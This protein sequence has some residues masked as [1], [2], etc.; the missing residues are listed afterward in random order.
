MLK[1]TIEEQSERVSKRVEW[2]ES[3]YKKWEERFEIPF[4]Q[5]FNIKAL[6]GLRHQFTATQDDHVKTK[7]DLLWSMQKIESHLNLK[8]K[9]KNKYIETVEKRIER[10]QTSLNSIEDSIKVAN[11]NG[12]ATDDLKLAK[13]IIEEKLTELGHLRSYF[14]NITK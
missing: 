3:E 13:E 1:N 10:L 11:H 8:P 6:L 9:K 7:M 12:K 14:Y 4:E 2:V 5:E